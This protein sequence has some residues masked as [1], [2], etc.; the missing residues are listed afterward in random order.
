MAA[1]KGLVQD[2]RCLCQAPTHPRTASA[3]ASSYAQ[4]QSQQWDKSFAC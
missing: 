2:S 4:K 3:T 1:Y